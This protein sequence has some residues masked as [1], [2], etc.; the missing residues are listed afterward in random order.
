L[1]GDGTGGGAIGGFAFGGDGGNG[2]NG[3]I[4]TTGLGGAGG[5]GGQWG[6][7]NG[8]DGI[9]NGISEAHAE[10]AIDLTAFNQSIVMGA[11][12]QGNTIDMTVVGGD[13][14]STFTGEDV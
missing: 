9:V 13:L 8:D 6:S 4:A 1:G 2:G 5:A 14:T 10:A 3:G 11:N 12:L 7:G